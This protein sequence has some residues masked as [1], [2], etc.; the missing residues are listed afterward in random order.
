MRRTRQRD[1]EY[2]ARIIPYSYNGNGHNAIVASYTVHDEVY[3]HVDILESESYITLFL[4]TR[5]YDRALSAA[6][7]AG[8]VIFCRKVDPSY[9]LRRIE[10]LNLHQEPITI[11]VDRR[12]IEVS[13]ELEITPVMEERKIV[14]EIAQNTIDKQ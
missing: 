10:F 12:E 13:P 6:K 14:V 8:R 2:E 1:T 7:K 4:T 9:K 3:K 5:S 11:E